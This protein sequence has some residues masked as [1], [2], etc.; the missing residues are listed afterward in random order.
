MAVSDNLQRIMPTDH[1]RTRG[2]VLDYKEAVLLTN[3]ANST[4]RGQVNLV[5]FHYTFF[6]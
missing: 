2:Q 5:S 3:P 1:D 4:L 6:L